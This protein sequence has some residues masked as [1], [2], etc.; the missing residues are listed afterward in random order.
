MQDEG[1]VST[2]I[3]KSLV[4]T[5]D[6]TEIQ[7]APTPDDSHENGEIDWQADGDVHEA[8]LHREESPSAGKRLRTNDD[9]QEQES[10]QG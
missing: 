1:A 3:A 6:S 4:D 7:L 9:D 5:V 2:E 8:E 10:G